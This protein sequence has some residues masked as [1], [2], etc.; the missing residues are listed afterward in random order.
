M[1]SHTATSGEGRVTFGC[2]EGNESRRVRRQH[3]GPRA[4]ARGY[5]DRSGAMAG[6]ETVSRDTPAAGREGS[7]E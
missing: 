3:A 5:S 7:D 2:C 1:A 4:V 6:I